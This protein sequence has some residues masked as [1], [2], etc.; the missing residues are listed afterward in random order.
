MDKTA[1]LS[2]C[3]CET[4]GWKATA[5]AGML[6]IFVETCLQNPVNFAC[7]LQFTRS[8]LVYA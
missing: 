5:G 6:L 1:R 8:N 3:K 7:T 4:Q 2:G